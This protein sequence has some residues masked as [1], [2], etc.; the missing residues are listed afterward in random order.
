MSKSRR[1]PSPQEIEA[2]VDTAGQG[3]ILAVAAFLA[4][5]PGA[6]DRRNAAGDTALIAAAAKGQESVVRLLL[7]HGANIE[8]NDNGGRTPLLCAAWLGQTPIVELLLESGANLDAEDHSGLGAPALAVWGGFPATE[9]F[10]RQWAAA[11]KNNPKD[12]SASPALLQDVDSF[13]TAA[14]LGKEKEVTAFLDQHP[15]AIDRK[16]THGN[17][18]LIYAAWSGQDM[19]VELLL[20]KGAAVDLPNDDGTTALMAAALKGRTGTARILLEKGAAIDVT[21]HKDRTALMIAREQGHI[22]IAALIVQHAEAR[23]RR[24]QEAFEAEIRK[25]VGA[26]IAK[27][28]NR[29]PKPPFGKGPA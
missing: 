21:G 10:L 14:G 13:V 25:R 2:F 6:Q 16:N 24:A 12:A 17:T 23:R 11:R 15:A 19:M 4:R 3:D 8:E 29:R 18:A 7:K 9:Q 1:A 26:R 5:H 27:L 20:G 22:E 28:K